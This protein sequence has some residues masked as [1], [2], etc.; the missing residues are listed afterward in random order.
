MPMWL[1]YMEIEVDQ[2]HSS[3]SSGTSNFVLLGRRG[4]FLFSFGSAEVGEGHGHPPFDSVRTEV[5][6]GHPRWYD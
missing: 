4:P 3:V 6:H 5:G 2:G 1:C